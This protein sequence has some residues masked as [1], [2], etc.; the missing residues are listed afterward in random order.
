MSAQLEEIS[1]PPV[2]PEIAPFVASPAA[3][4][5]VLRPAS[6][7]AAELPQPLDTHPVRREGDRGLTLLLLFLGATSVMVVDVVV[8]SAVDRWWVLIPA[9]VVLLL[10]TLVVF[11]GIMR[12]LADGAEPTRRDGR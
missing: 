10:M 6:Q 8:A 7:D 3:P 11:T 1:R 12:L 5:R 4:A 2:A 9:F